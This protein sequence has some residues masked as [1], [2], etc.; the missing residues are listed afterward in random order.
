MI[1]PDDSQFGISSVVMDCIDKKSPSPSQ[2]S[3][4]ID[5]SG[6]FC[7]LPG[8]SSFDHL[9]PDAENLLVSKMEPFLPS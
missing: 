5:G 8:G 6:V 9:G 3:L 7:K 2:Y 4:R 1:E